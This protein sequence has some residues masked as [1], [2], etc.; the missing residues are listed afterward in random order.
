MGAKQGREAE[1]IEITPEMIE[2]GAAAVNRCL[3]ASEILPPMT[4]EDLASQVF[5]AMAKCAHN[6][7]TAPTHLRKGEGREREDDTV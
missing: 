1:K 6:A 2:V 7:N 4:E 5:A 3:G